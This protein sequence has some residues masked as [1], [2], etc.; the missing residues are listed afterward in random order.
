MGN[1][2]GAALTNLDGSNQIAT[3]NALVPPEGPKAIYTSLDFTTLNT[4]IVDFTLAV[5]QGKITAIQSIWVDN[6]SNPQPLQIT[7]QGTQQ[8]ITCP[9]G[10]QGTFPVIA[11]NRPKFTCVTNGTLVVN[12]IWLNVPIPA[13]LW[14][15]NQGSASVASA[16]VAHSIA[17]GGTAQFVWTAGHAPSGGA[18]IKNPTAAAAAEVLYIDIVNAAQ[19]AEPGTNGTTVALAAGDDFVIPPNFGGA[20]SVNALTTNHA[21][22]AY[23]IASVPA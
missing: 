4:N 21:F 20:V 7:V 8:V 17:T 15:P 18:L 11:A 9:A 13:N 10:A 2:V 3:L 12:I 5:S 23:G 6:S 19:T 16:A 14:Y 22:V 1:V